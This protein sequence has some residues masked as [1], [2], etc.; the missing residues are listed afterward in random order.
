[1]K[2]I[3]PYFRT[4]FPRVP[5][6]FRAAIVVRS[7]L[8]RIVFQ[9]SL[10][11]TQSL[12]SASF[13]LKQPSADI[14]GTTRLTATATYANCSP[15]NVSSRF[16]LSSVDARVVR[17]ASGSATGSFAITPNYQWKTVTAFMSSSIGNSHWN[18]L[19]AI[20]ATR[21]ARIFI[22]QRSP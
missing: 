21:G 22:C 6:P 10:S 3:S 1:M 7:A 20:S 12:A 8:A 13:S 15:G 2:S 5:S 19:R 14:R 4:S 11:R 16:T 9:P 18:A 17:I